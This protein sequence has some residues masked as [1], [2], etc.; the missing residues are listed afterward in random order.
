M[1]WLLGVLVL[2]VG[3]AAVP[4][5]WAAEVENSLELQAAVEAARD[6]VL[7]CLVRVQP[8]SELYVGGRKVKRSGFGSG[9]IFTHEGH[10]LTNYHV[11]GRAK[12]LLCV[13]AD[14]EEIP[15]TLVAGDPWTDLAV[16]KLDLDRYKGHELRW[17]VL[18]DSDKLEVGEFV[19]ALGSPYALTRTLTFGVVSC[20]D[21]SLGVRVDLPGEMGLQET[22]QFNTWIQVDALINPGNSGG[23]LINMRGEVV[24]IN[25][26]GGAGMGFAIP[27]NVAKDVARE[28]IEH[29]KVRRSWI[30]VEFQALAK[31]ADRFVGDAAEGGVLV[32]NVVA[33]SPASKADIRPGDVMLTFDGKPT[34][35]RFEEEIYPIARMV[36]RTEIEKT[37]EV[38]VLRRKKHVTVRVTT[39]DLGRAVGE[40]F[41]CE[42]WGLTVKDIT[43]SMARML[44]LD[45]DQGVLATGS[46]SDSVASKAK[47]GNR[48][49][50]REIAGTKIRDLDHLKEVY[51]KVTAAKPTKV[52][53][54]VL[55]GGRTP[56]LLVL[57]LA[58]A[59]KEPGKSA[60]PEG[61]EK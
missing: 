58:E 44:A 8:I 22:G 49:V 25:A 24:G 23:P 38:T 21:R 2:S 48:D 7:P 37:V 56:R 54:K 28:L 46:L 41:V 50:I 6:R 59:V 27:M 29:G 19:I 52:I 51:A 60:K 55:Q 34:H 4:A 12:S 3:L 13:M 20:K 40:D 30:G 17:A 57:N 26:R 11:A 15:A 42:A 32:G 16:I 36:A 10:V 39:Q 1:K 9:V 14:K 5:T 43:P 31:F 53:M 47:I 33:D 18:G 35:A 45:D 61:S